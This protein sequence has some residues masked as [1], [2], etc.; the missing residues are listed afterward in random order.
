MAPQPVSQLQALLIQNR[1]WVRWMRAGGISLLKSWVLLL[2][3]VFGI[4]VLAA[5]SVPLLT[6]LG[7]D[8]LAKPLFSA[9][10]LICAQI[11][12]HSFYLLG[13]QLGLD[14][15]CLAIYSALCVGGLVF[16]V[17]R[18]RLP[19]LPWWGLVLMALPLVYDGGTQLIGLRQST[20]EMRLI[21]G[22][23]FGVGAAWFA[24]P[25]LHKTIQENLPR[26]FN[27]GR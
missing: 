6:Y 22:M 16:V 10:H 18:K 4:I 27:D 23:L 26:S 2:S 8:A 14:V 9:L 21:T 25:W 1:R 24:F 17:S 20:W 7:L 3:I 19:S 11:P 15:H 13:H 5:V 12:S